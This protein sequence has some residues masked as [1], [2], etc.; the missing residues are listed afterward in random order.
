MD[1]ISKQEKAV[2][3]D[4]A[5]GKVEEEIGSLEELVR[6]VRDGGESAPP[7]EEKSIDSLLS[8]SQLLA[9]TPER[10]GKLAESIAKAV[11]ELKDSLF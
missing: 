4:D 1:G 5:I 10:L 6:K 3:I 11:A 7:E 9:E 2:V 8:L